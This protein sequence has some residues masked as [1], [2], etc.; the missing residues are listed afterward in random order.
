MIIL[1]YISGLMTAL[2]AGLLVFAIRAYRKYTLLLRAHD[3]STELYVEI[4]DDI[5]EWMDDTD[6]DLNYIKAG[7]EDNDYANMKVI[8]DNVEQL[9]QRLT[10][11]N[12]QTI[13]A[14]DTNDKVITGLYSD[15]HTLKKQVI[16][17]GSDPNTISRY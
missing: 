13:Q 5:E 8:S 6:I 17:L 16:H 1:T 2:L 4:H 14:R 10:V 7:M 11:I 12:N 3:I 9:N 15:L